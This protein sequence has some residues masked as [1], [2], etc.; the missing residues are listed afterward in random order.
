MLVFQPQSPELYVL[1]RE[2]ARFLMQTNQPQLAVSLLE[3]LRQNNPQNPRILS[4]LIS[5]Y[6]QFDQNK[7]NE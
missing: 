6:S 4:L 2:N 5:A 7:A 3:R 1:Y